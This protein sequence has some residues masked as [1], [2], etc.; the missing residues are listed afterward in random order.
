[1]TAT[2]A[3]GEVRSGNRALRAVGAGE[4]AYLY[5]AGKR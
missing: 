4:Q 3:D 5:T 1:M 2:T